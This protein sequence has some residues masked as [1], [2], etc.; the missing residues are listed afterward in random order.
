MYFNALLNGLANIPKISKATKQK[1]NTLTINELLDS[2][3]GE[4]LVGI[5]NNNRAR[6][7]RAWEVQKET[8]ESLK[9]WQKRTPS[10]LVQFNEVDAIV[11]NTPK[12][13]LE[14][15]IVT[16]FDQMLKKGLV[17]EVRAMKDKWDTSKVY[18]KAIGAQEIL[19]YIKNETDLKTAR[20]KSIIATRQY[21]KR[22]RTWFKK[23]MTNWRTYGE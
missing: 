11:L 7:Q 10:P 5:D 23:N 14:S 3:D 12:K 22:Q 19:S 20:E 16:R 2:I 17:E 13:V 1:A 21:A 18:T 15:R 4:T 6:V 8:G 9:S